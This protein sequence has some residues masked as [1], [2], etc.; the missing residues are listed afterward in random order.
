MLT[1]VR[2]DETTFGNGLVYIPH[3]TIH[4]D[5]HNANG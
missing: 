3:V 4:I 2:H 5:S 1:A